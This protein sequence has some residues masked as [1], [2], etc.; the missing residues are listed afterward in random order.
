MDYSI[1]DCNL[2]AL[3]TG[4]QMEKSIYSRQYTCFLEIL[5]ATREQLG[6][7][8][9]D[10]A[11]RLNETQSFVSKCE[12]GE[13]RLDVVELRAWCSALGVSLPTFVTRF[14]EACGNEPNGQ[15]CQH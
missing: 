11:L 6:L 15:C 9:E 7:T 10:V 8:Q 3:L 5:R 14:D 12:R 1:L 4:A 2:L 13:R